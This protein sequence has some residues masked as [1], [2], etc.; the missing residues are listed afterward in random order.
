MEIKGAYKKSMRNLFAGAREGVVPVG[1]P[2]VLACGQS[3]CFLVGLITSPGICLHF[4][5]LSSGVPCK[6]QEPFQRKH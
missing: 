3:D 4:R 2:D 5:P 6:K 1:G